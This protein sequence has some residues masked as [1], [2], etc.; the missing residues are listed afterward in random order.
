MWLA[1]WTIYFLFF[2]NRRY[3]LYYRKLHSYRERIN[4]TVFLAKSIVFN[5]KR[6]LYFLLSYSNVSIPHLFHLLR[7]LSCFPMYL[8]W[9]RN[10]ANA[11]QN[12]MNGRKIKKNRGV[13]TLQYN[14]KIEGKWLC[15]E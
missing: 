7:F 11:S 15:G 4:S 6:F 14:V 8:H 10:E 2:P 3:F 9:S 1:Y 5:N 13:V 12:H